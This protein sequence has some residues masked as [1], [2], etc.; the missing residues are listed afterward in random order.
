MGQLLFYNS[1]CRSV[2]KIFFSRRLTYTWVIPSSRA[3]WVWVL[4]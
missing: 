2:S 4:P 1:I 3:V